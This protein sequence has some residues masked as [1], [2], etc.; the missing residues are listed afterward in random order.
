[1]SK[2]EKEME[3]YAEEKYIAF[4]KKGIKHF[5]KLIR[6][7]LEEKDFGRDGDLDYK[8]LYENSVS[9]IDKQ[10]ALIESYENIIQSNLNRKLEA[11]EGQFM[12]GYNAGYNSELDKTKF[13]EHFD[14]VF[15]DKNSN[16]HLVNYKG[17]LEISNDDVEITGIEY[18]INTDGNYDGSE[19]KL[20]GKLIK[21][22]TTITLINITNYIDI[23]QFTHMD[24]N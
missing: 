3:K 4:M 14:Y 13:E 7:E 17:E 24:I 5:K 1:M 22:Q 11:K 18:W 2:S 20:I 8:E 21:K 23:K 6:E 15:V 10:S 9:V 12:I 19:I 16:E